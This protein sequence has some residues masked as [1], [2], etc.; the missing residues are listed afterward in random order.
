MAINQLSAGV[1]V[2][3]IDL[4]TTVP[5]VSTSTGA[6]AGPFQWG[7]VGVVSPIS[8]EVQL[9]SRFGQPVDSITGSPATF[10]SAANF[11]QYSGSLNVVR[12]FG[13][14]GIGNSAT[15]ATGPAPTASLTLVKNGDD[16]NARYNGT[17]NIPGLSWIGRYP[18]TIGNSL[19]VITVDAAT[20]SG[21]TGFNTTP[22][23]VAFNTLFPTA[24]GTSAYA[25]MFVWIGRKTIPALDICKKQKNV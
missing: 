4:T 23:F 10:F 5:A 16:Y 14:T 9:V 3:E 18:G 21:A 12:A 17:T 1:N 6:I 19:R 22:G 13:A 15:G 8:N 11:L 2:S 24:P 20:Y 25:A 7:P